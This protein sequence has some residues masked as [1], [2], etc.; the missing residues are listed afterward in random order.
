[1]I[2]PYLPTNLYTV[3]LGGTVSNLYAH[4]LFLCLTRISMNNGP[5]TIE[6]ITPTG[7]PFM[8]DTLANVSARTKNAAPKA[9]EAGIK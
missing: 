4:A 7:K 5:P 2:Y 1:M 3:L 8:P 6:Q 9:A